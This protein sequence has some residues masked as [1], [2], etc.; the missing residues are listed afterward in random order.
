MEDKSP[1]TLS[2]NQVKLVNAALDMYLSTNC[3]CEHCDQEEADLV[4]LKQLFGT[5]QTELEQVLI[6]DIRLNGEK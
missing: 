3:D 2:L 4:T 5:A 6:D 1:F